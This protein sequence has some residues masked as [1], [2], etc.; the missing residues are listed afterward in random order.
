MKRD[1]KIH[2]A[3]AEQAKHVEFF[4]FHPDTQEDWEHSYYL[5]LGEVAGML[6]LGGGQATLVSGL[7][8]LAH[9]TPLLALSTF[10]GAA[11][12]VWLFA[13]GQP[14]ITRADHAV[15]GSPTWT[16]GAARDLVASLRRQRTL[17]E[18]EGRAAGE[19]E[20]DWLRLKKL[21]AVAGIMSL[22]TAALLASIAFVGTKDA[23]L[24]SL[25]FFG[26]PIAAGFAGALVKVLIETARDPSV[27]FE[28][29]VWLDALFGMGAGLVASLA[30]A[31]AHLMT[32]RD[33][34]VL[35]EAVTASKGGLDV[36]LLFLLAIGFGA[37][38]TSEAVFGKLQKVDVLR[39]DLFEG[40]QD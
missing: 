39:T 35:A 26:V 18:E 6:L 20:K 28:Q 37:G 40:S 25:G 17:I 15:M 33:I 38:Y 10:G 30:F 23:A 22:L 24:Y 7:M 31:A 5:S 9:R 32:H 21:R 12:K 36:L 13:K 14:W 3:F 4:N 19:R 27:R 16:P 8:A 29:S 1:P 34:G 2:G 11:Q